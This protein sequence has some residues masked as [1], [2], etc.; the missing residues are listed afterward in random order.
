MKFMCWA[1]CRDFMFL[2]LLSLLD[3]SL[4]ILLPSL[5]PNQRPPR[6][7]ALTGTCVQTS[8]LCFKYL[9]KAVQNSDKSCCHAVV[10][11]F[12]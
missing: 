10:H 1:D 9:H 8:I 11:S 7:A 12:C 5:A 2:F 3:T 6:S 4:S